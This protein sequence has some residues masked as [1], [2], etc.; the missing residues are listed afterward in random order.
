MAITQAFSVKT[1]RLTEVAVRTAKRVQKVLA[2]H[3]RLLDD[4]TVDTGPKGEQLALA[5]LVGA[6]ASGLGLAGERAGKPLL[7][8]VDPAKARVAERVGESLG[9]NVHA[10]VAVPAR[11]RA[12]LERLC[13]YVC[14]PPIAQERLVEVAGGKLRYLL[15]KPWSDGTVA[16]VLEPL[17]L[18]ARIAALIPPPRFHMIRYH[19]V[20][21]SHAKPASGLGLV[22]ERAGQ[23]LLRIVDPSRAREGEPFAEVMGFNVHAQVAVAAHDRARLERLCR[24]L[25]RPPLAQERLEETPSGKLRYTFK[26]P[27][28]DGTVALL[29]E[30]LDLIA[31]VCALVPPPRL[32]MVRYHGVLSSHAK[33]RSEVVPKPEV[34]SLATRVVQLEL[35]G[36]NNDSSDTEPRRRPWAW[37]LRHV[38]EVD[39]TTCPHCTGPMRWLE[40]ATTSD[41]IARLLAKHG[42]GPRP[43]PKDRAPHGQLR[44]AF[45][46]T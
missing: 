9:V 7:R 6:A 13:R 31:R 46:K 23:P 37:L 4:A 34:A 45:P 36:D 2:R 24:Y 20:L 27:W 16:L 32:H 15:K 19:G 44:L 35:F 5:A 28:K 17:D 39:V 18:C 33:V 10:E 42:L 12:R 25:C 11:D 1:Q 41:A 38:F 26:K 40:A 29:L 8:V 21:S 30:P 3:G 43:P 14:R 22:G